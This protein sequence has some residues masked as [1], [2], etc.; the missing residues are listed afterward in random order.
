MRL[1]FLRP[2]YLEGCYPFSST[3]EY[4]NCEILA[5]KSRYG[6]RPMAWG[7]QKHSPYLDIF[8]FYIRHFMENGAWDAIEKTHQSPQR[9]PD[10][11][12]SSLQLAQCVTSF[13][14]V[15]SGLILASLTY[16]IETCL[17][18]LDVLRVEQP[19]RGCKVVFVQPR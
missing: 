15:F 8:N 16:L 10:T 3:K 7:F 17:K 5:T 13:L 9:C 6:A 1:K 18:G 12:G 4:K 14:I 19:R 2:T 11:S